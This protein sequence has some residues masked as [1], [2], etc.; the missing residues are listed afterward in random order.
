MTE[1]KQIVAK[2]QTKI[3]FQFA[4]VCTSKEV[5]ENLHCAALKSVSLV[6]RSR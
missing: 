1:Y 4:A 6:F 3:L 2:M 5:L